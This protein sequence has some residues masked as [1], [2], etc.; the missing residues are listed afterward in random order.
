MLWKEKYEQYE[1]L[2][3][4]AGA[5][6]DKALDQY[7]KLEEELYGQKMLDIFSDTEF[8]FSDMQELAKEAE[9]GEVANL[10]EKFAEFIGL[11]E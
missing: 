10:V 7:L 2:Y 1:A 5:G 11:P 3:A 8:S 9:N 6:S 4:E